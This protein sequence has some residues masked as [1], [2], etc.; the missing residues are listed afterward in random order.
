MRERRGQVEAGILR[1]NAVPG[2]L[3]TAD[4]GEHDQRAQANRRDLDEG[5]RPA[6]DAS[7]PGRRLGWRREQVGEHGAGAV[8]FP[9]VRQ[10][11]IGPGLTGRPEPR[12]GHGWKLSQAVFGRVSVVTGPDLLPSP[13]LTAAAGPPGA[14][15]CLVVGDVIDDAEPGWRVCRLRITTVD[16]GDK[17]AVL[18]L[19]DGD[20]DAITLDQ[21]AALAQDPGREVAQHGPLL[22]VEIDRRV[23]DPTRAIAKPDLLSELAC[24]RTVRR[25]L[26]QPKPR[27][28]DVTVGD[29]GH[30][31]D[32]CWHG[33]DEKPALHL[34]MRVLP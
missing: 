1:V 7:A 16:L 32:A 9:Q 18:E 27:A 20:G 3:R 25:D 26:A 23:C 21:V 14:G 28:V 8:A 30:L 12:T 22:L 11:C 6:R 24:C 15:E 4:P 31:R 5:E 17:R 29:V 13:G 10:P 34:D 33:A 2:R 19:I